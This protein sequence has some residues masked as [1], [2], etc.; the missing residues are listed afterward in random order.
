MDERNQLFEQYGKTYKKGTLIFSEGDI[1]EQVYLIQSG[2]IR[3]FKL[4]G[5]QDKTL[6]IL[7]PGDFLGEMAIIEKKP[8]SASAE[9]LI[10]SNLLVLDPS[11]FE[12]LI[13]SNG[14]IALKVIK[15]LVSRLRNTD[16]LLECISLSDPLHRIVALFVSLGYDS[17][18]SNEPVEILHGLDDIAK[19]C[20]LSSGTAEAIIEKLVTLNL[21]SFKE[22]RIK[23]I[24]YQGLVNYKEILNI[25]K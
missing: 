19:L 22:Q 12:E 5:N 2:K 11:T 10:D 23:I 9:A 13:R 24:D 21:I 1:G 6:A 18:N 14:E 20:G 25:G 17:S 7:G 3:V 4:L 15:R 16:T 8:R